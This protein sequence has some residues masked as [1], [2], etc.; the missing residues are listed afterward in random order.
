MQDDGDRIFGAKVPNTRHIITIHIIYTPK[1]IVN[2]L[3][4]P[5]Q[6]Y[7]GGMDLGRKISNDEPG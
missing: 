6:S 4:P 2:D 3:P 7:Y 5:R 1:F